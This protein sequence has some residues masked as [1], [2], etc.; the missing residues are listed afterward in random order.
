[1]RL[2]ERERKREKG[3]RAKKNGA[4]EEICKEKERHTEGKKTYRQRKSKRCIWTE[5]KTETSK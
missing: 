5:K 3:E 4:R 2:K 1:M